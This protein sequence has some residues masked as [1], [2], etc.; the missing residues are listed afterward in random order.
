MFLKYSEI[1]NSFDSGG[2][3]K[4]T[5]NNRRM[6]K[7]DLAGD[8]LLPTKGDRLDIYRNEYNDMLMDKALGT[9]SMIQD[10]YM[11]NI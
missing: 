5:I 11:T 6:D 9:S 7:R 1:L 8:I 3:T 2:T 10:K 4:I